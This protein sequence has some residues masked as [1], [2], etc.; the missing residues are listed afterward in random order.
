MSS[1]DEKISKGREENKIVTLFEVAPGDCDHFVGR[2]NDAVMMQF[3][4]LSVPL[5]DR[6]NEYSDEDEEGDFSSGDD[7][8]DGGAA[9]TAAMMR[10]FSNKSNFRKL[11][12]HRLNDNDP[13]DV[14]M[15]GQGAQCDSDSDFDPKDKNART[16]ISR[17]SG[18]QGQCAAATV[19][20]GHGSECF[21]DFSTWDR[22]SDM[23]KR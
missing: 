4:S 2:S 14:V 1:I 19:V 9:T 17:V 20:V 11:D 8:E 16:K 6:N 22:G 23:G 15:L 13:E 3:T 10:N 5:S 7:N 21:C 12:H 18:N